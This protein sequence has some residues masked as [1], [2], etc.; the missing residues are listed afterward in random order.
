MNWPQVYTC[1]P[2]LTPHSASFSTL[3]LWVVPETS[4]GCPASCI[5]FA[6]DICF[7]YGN[8][9]VAVLFSQIIP[10]SASPTVDIVCS[11]AW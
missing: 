5:E 7:T 11:T 4:F 6:L 8:I 1:P 9:H 10:D 3:S 2:I